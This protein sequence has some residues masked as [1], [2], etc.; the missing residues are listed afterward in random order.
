MCKWHLYVNI[1]RLHT[2]SVD[3]TAKNRFFSFYRFRELVAKLFQYPVISVIRF[4]VP[5]TESKNRIPSFE[6]RPKLPD[7]FAIRFKVGGKLTDFRVTD[8]DK[9]YL[10]YLQSQQSLAYIYQMIQ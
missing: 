1:F 5:E 9:N 2:K 3:S 8:S 10:A 6:N 4:R 7:F